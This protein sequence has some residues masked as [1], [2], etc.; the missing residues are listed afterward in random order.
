MFDI[1]DRV[2][3]DRSFRQDSH[4]FKPGDKGTILAYDSFRILVEWDFESTWFHNGGQ[5]CRVL[6]R[7]VYGKN[8]H[9]YYIEDDRVNCLRIIPRKRCNGGFYNE[10]N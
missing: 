6:D 5:Y 4:N 8:K 10:R 9:C 3:V 7:D 1:G 2:I